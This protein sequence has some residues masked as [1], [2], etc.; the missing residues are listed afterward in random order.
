[1]D[2]NEFILTRHSERDH[3]ERWTRLRKVVNDDL[4]RVICMAND[5]K[6]IVCIT[7][8]GVYGVIN[9]VSKVLITAYLPTVSKARRVYQYA[10]QEMPL[11]VLRM[12]RHNEK[13]ELKILR[14]CA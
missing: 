10:E 4:G 9:P 13:K 12:L 8:T 7:S 14:K 1:M 6:G 3:A 11:E 2:L 5:G